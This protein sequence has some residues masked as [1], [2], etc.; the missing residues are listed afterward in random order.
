MMSYYHLQKVKDSSSYQQK[1]ST[2]CR[3]LP[4]THRQVAEKYINLSCLQRY[5]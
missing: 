1:L 5:L 2:V 3:Y 4:F